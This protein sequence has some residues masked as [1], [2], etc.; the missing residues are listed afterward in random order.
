MLISIDIRRNGLMFSSGDSVQ[1][2][3]ALKLAGKYDVIVV[4]GGPAGCIAAA[5][6]ARNGANT[7]LIERFGFLGGVMTFGF[8][9]GGGLN[10]YTICDTPT[11][12]SPYRDALKP[13][14]VRGISLELYNRMYRDGVVKDERPGIR[15][16]MDAILLTHTLDE[17][18]AEEGVT[19][20]LNTNAFDAVVEN[21]AVKGVAVSNK[22]GGQVYLAD[23]VV[24]ASAD[25]DIAAAAGA[26]FTFGRWDGKTHG[27][28][29]D[30][31]IGGFDIKKFVKFMKEQPNLPDDERAQLELDRSRLIGGG[32]P[33]NTSVTYDGKLATINP[34]GYVTDWAEAER[35]LEAGEMPKITIGGGGGGPYPGTV[36]MKDGKYVPD[37][38]T[39]IKKWI[40]YIK[41]G[42]VPHLMG[43]ILPVYPA[44]RYASV[45]TPRYGKFRLGEMESGSYEVFVDQTNEKEISAAMAYMRKLNDVYVA[46]LREKIPGFEDCYV[47]YESPVPGTRESRSIVGEYT[48]DDE[49]VFQGRSFD[50][51]IAVGGPRGS[52]THS[53]TGIWGDGMTS[54]LE[55]PFG[56]PYRMIV[57]KELDN[58]LTSGRC[59]SA[60]F[61]AFGAIRDQ[62]NCMSLGEAAGT[63]AALASKKGI[64]PRDL[65]VKEIQEALSAQGAVWSLDDVRV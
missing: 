17:M 40:D 30:I 45:V 42:K 8:L 35:Q 48:L 28:S 13:L 4:G 24:D 53:I 47:M 19:V 55:G 2:G 36:P 14:S 59:V 20:L 22:S 44:P 58:L 39:F 62:A 49:D 6:A 21:G 29:L 64:K 52:S 50:D 38:C 25:G 65:D 51:S 10:G 41:E 5:A 60:T 9:G 3:A 15:I 32:R 37:P 61:S 34:R 33:P 57:P 63:A 1:K 43:A 26:E 23:V 56:L 31:I 46:F 16:Q 12:G 7:L 27:I 18:M 11:E 54:T